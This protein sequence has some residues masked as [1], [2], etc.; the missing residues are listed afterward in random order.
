[1]LSWSNPNLTGSIG[2]EV[3]VRK[4]GDETINNSTTLQNDNHLVVSV[5]SNRTYRIEGVLYARSN[6]NSIDL[7]LAL[8]IPANA[9]IKVR[10]FAHTNSF[11]PRGGGFLTADATSS[12]TVDLVANTGTDVAVEFEGVVITGNTNGSVQV[13]WAQN[14][15]AASSTLTVETNSFM[16][17]KRVE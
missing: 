10:Y 3:F 14:A 5:D 9:T 15:N 13:Q 17:V 12:G 6:M 11:I 7:K 8:D 16:E 4:T 2:S 1:V